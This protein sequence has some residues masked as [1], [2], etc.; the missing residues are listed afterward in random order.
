MK[1]VTTETVQRCLNVQKEK[2]LE[3]GIVL[4][5]RYS[6]KITIVKVASENNNIYSQGARLGVITCCHNYVFFSLRTNLRV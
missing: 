3:V 4:H 2:S 5:V 1:A 6:L